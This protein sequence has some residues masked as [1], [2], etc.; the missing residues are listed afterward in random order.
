MTRY[1]YLTILWPNKTN[2]TPSCLCRWTASSTSPRTLSHLPSYFVSLPCLAARSYA[3]FIKR[4]PVH[5]LVVSI[6]WLSHQILVDPMRNIAY[7]IVQI[8]WEAGHIYRS[9]L[10]IH[11]QRF[12]QHEGL[13]MFKWLAA[14][15]DVTGR[16]GQLHYSGLNL[17]D[18]VPSSGE[19]LLVITSDIPTFYSL[20][21]LHFAYSGNCG[22][23]G[24]HS[25]PIIYNF[26]L[27]A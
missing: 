8:V 9:I 12:F 4:T 18:S 25:E 1:H 22:E 27:F 16:N 3:C 14:S 10:Q 6:S 5:C 19:E 17:P 2:G 13:R 15:R 24:T 21:W 11:G 23:V 20:H 7:R 26:L